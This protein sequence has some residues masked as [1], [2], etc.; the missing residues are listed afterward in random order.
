[1]SLVGSLEDLGLGDVLQIV[2]LSRKSGLLSVRGE[3]GEGAILLRD[4]SVR[5]AHLKGEPMDLREAIVGGR[6]L[7]AREFDA[8]RERAVREGTRLED[9]LA[10]HTSM[11]AE[12]IELLRRDCVEAAVMAMFA[13]ETGEFRFERDTELS[14]ED[15]PFFLPTGISAQYL[16]MEGSRIKDEAVRMRR[17]WQRDAGVGVMELSLSG[18]GV[19][20][21]VR[22]RSEGAVEALAQAAARRADLSG[23]DCTG[24]EPS[25]SAFEPSSEASAFAELPA[26]LVVI[27]PDL[28]AL[29][30][31]KG[32]LE[33]AFPRIHV[34]QRWDLGL[35]PIRQYLARAQQPVVILKP[36]AQGDLLSG[37][38][39]S[40]DF[41][42]RLKA[43]HASLPVLWLQED[44]AAEWN[45]LVPADGVVT[46]PSTRQLRSPRAAPRR[47]ELAADLR[48]D[49]AA[50]LLPRT[51]GFGSDAGGR[52]AWP[53]PPAPSPALRS[54]QVLPEDDGQF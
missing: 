4:G 21:Q 54:K 34:F 14:A 16:A 43:Q 35:G 15:L 6:F 26:P 39:N 45:D 8:A 22:G 25:R 49:L 37:I 46:R 24:T 41:V 38:R 3:G 11:T 31:V 12:R 53:L 5:S 44:G 28:L 23:A 32:T 42:T 48:S 18:S 40:A 7:E 50:V 36:E 13:W 2:S 30:W 51:G 9:A 1:M 10:A 52:E 29:E 47:R 17:E 27:D 33:S 19:G 20:S